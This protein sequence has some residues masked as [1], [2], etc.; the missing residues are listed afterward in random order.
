MKEA[1][2]RGRGGGGVAG[3]MHRVRKFLPLM[4]VRK[5]LPLMLM[6]ECYVN[7]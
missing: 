3:Y 2:G 6:R 4:R 1:W 7:G 5:K